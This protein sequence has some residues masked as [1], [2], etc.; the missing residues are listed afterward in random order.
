[1]KRK[2]YLL[3][4][5]VEWFEQVDEDNGGDNDKLDDAEVDKEP[6]LS[7][8]DIMDADGEEP[9]DELDKAN[10]PEKVLIPVATDPNKC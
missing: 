1:M 2:L 3:F 7:D 6:E 4:F 9:I 10:F 5:T 8:K